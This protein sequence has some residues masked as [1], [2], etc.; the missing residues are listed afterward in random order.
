MMR[1]SLSKWRNSC[2]DCVSACDV[3]MS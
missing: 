2:S 3:S 1:T